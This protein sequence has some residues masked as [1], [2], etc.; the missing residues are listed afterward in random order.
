MLSRDYPCVCGHTKERHLDTVPGGDKCYLCWA[1]AG[2]TVDWKKVC[3]TFVP[4]NLRYLE[5]LSAES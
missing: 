3:I 1:K 5:S 4:D 2:D